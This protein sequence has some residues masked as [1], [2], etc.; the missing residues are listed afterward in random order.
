MYIQQLKI[1]KERIAVLIGT[2]AETKREIEKKT[3]TE[4]E[5][6]S[7]DGSV[8]I[9]GE[10]SLNVY[11]TKFIIQAI[12]RGFNPELALTLLDEDYCLEIINIKDYCGNSKKKLT[13]LKSR[14]IGT[15]GNARKNIEKMTNT[16]ICVYGKTISILGE[17][18][19]VLI[20]KEAVICLLK[21]AP[22]GNA[23][24]HIE[25]LSR[26]TL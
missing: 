10:D 2:K 11:L 26:K 3:N 14:L 23:Y 9:K 18:N 12:A 1:P 6:S 21:G 19:K 13:R 22:H 16:N 20:A 24:K 4:L 5:I 17:L 8:L 25:K 15:G 7:E